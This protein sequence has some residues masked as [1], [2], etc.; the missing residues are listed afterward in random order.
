MMRFHYNTNYK[1]ANDD[2]PKNYF[3]VRGIGDISAA[4]KYRFSL[5]GSLLPECPR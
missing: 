1:G 4:N 3:S 2:V 5:W